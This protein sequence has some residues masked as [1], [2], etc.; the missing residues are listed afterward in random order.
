MKITSPQGKKKAAASKRSATFTTVPNTPLQLLGMYRKVKF[1]KLN[2][3]EQLWKKEVLA[4][5]ED[6]A[7]NC[8]LVIAYSDIKLSELARNVEEA[9]NSYYGHE[10]TVGR[11]R[12]V[13]EWAKKTLQAHASM[14]SEAAFDR[15]LRLLRIS[16]NEM[17]DWL[18]S[19]IDD[20]STLRS[21]R[22][23]SGDQLFEDD[24]PVGLYDSPDVSR[25]A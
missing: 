3:N 6:A 4:A 18:L 12:D 9:V 16:Y 24:K 22:D 11:Y 7:H 10:E 2:A 19:L 17:G 14:K 20:G 5:A 23:L 8:Q 13:V 25:S 1:P 21:V 15:K